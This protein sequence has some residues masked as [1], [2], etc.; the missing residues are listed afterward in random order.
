MSLDLTILQKGII[1]KTLP[2]SVILGDRLHYGSFDES[3]RLRKKQMGGQGWF[4]A[5]LPQSIGR[6]IRIGWTEGEKE[7]ITL[8]LLYPTAQSE[9]QELAAIVDRVLCHWRGE[10]LMDGEKTSPDRWES[11]RWWMTRWN[12][13]LRTGFR[14]LC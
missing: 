1:K 10:L 7:K 14:R 11:S 12:K 6:G 5:Y 4:V 9:L 2:L 8:R 3:R 13:P